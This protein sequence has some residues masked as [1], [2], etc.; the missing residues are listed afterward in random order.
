MIKEVSGLPAEPLPPCAPDHEVRHYEDGIS[1]VGP[2]PFNI[3]YF[4]P[5]ALGGCKWN[6][7]ATAHLASEY[8]DLFREEKIRHNGH[9]LPYDSTIP[10]KDFENKIRIRL[11]RTQLHWKNAN[12]PQNNP[13]N[14]DVPT[15]LE[16]AS[17][18]MKENRFRRRG[19]KVWT[20]LC[21]HPLY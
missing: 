13:H 1:R 11:Q 19:A 9:V 10:V 15:P 12:R 14:T 4:W 7:Q 3:Q 20:L 18:R 5:G 21:I 8:H 6:K 16:L 2:D 17:L